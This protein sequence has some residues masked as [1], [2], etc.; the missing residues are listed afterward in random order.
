MVTRS[1]GD[2][3]VFRAPSLR[4]V[5][6]TP[7]YFHTGKVWELAEAV[8]VMGSSQLGAELTDE[9]AALIAA[10]LQTLTGRQPVVEYPILPPH[11][12]DTPRPDVSVGLP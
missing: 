2:E 7:P 9:E 1:P 6:L 12:P 11:T 10:Y 5:A 4:N 3:Y 8:R